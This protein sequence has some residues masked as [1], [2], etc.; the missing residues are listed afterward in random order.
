MN[1]VNQR[2]NPRFNRSFPVTLDFGAEI[3]FQGRA[4]EPSAYGA[5]VEISQYEFTRL[6]ENPAL[7]E[8][9][10]PITVSTRLNE[11]AAAV[12]SLNDSL[13]DRWLVSLK[14]LGGRTWY[15]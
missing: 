5:S 9:N 14:L 4:V 3:T 2:K 13:P 10:R 8:N 11:I 12:N 15:Q 1:Y 6:R 7:W